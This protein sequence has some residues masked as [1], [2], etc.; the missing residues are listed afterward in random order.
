MAR[1]NTGTTWHRRDDPGLQP[2]RTELA[3][4]RT[5]ISFV[6]AAL[7]L[8]RW[9]GRFGGLVVAMVGL[10]C[11]GAGYVLL[12]THRRTRLIAPTFPGRPVPVAIHQVLAV[13]VLTLA[14]GALGLA[15]TIGQLGP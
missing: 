6:A 15:I 14:L 11:V 7:L 3:W 1:A 5:M 8:T 2:E 13:T 9:A 4:Q 12:Q 10:A